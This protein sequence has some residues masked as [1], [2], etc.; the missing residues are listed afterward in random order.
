MKT[1]DA[2][3]FGGTPAA[4]SLGRIL[5]EL[6]D[7]RVATSAARA[8]AQWSRVLRNAALVSDKS[9]RSILLRLT[10]REA[11]RAIRE[12]QH[13][14]AVVRT[15]LGSMIVAAYRKYLTGELPRP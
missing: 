9:S 10:L 13:F 6:S 8:Y 15:H 2:S 1:Y 3:T 14:P 11:Q 5:T 4:H 12:D 7:Q